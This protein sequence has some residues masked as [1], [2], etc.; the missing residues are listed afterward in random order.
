MHFEDCFTTFQI[1]FIDRNL[2]VETAWAKQGCIKHIRSVCCCKN[3]NAAITTKAIH[4]NEQLI[5]C[6][7]TLIVAHN[8]ILSSCAANCI[9]FINKDYAWCFF[10]SLLE[11]ITNATCTDTHKQLNEIRTAHGEERNLCF[12]SHCF[13]K[14]SLTGPRRAD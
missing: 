13:C 8:R 3:N 1:W 7:F 12:A 9:N 2:S 5:Q 4:F 11:Q 14:Q 6:A 10:T